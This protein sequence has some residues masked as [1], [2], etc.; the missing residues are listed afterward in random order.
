M[1][2]PPALVTR[3]PQC[4]PGLL[5]RLDPG[6]WHPAY[7]ELRARC[8]LPLAPFGDFIAQIRYG[9]IVTGKRSPPCED[10]VVVIH[11]GQVGETGVDPRGAIRV[12]PGSDW[13][14]P[15]ARLRPDDLV[16]PR[17]GV[18]SLAR[19]RAAV[20]LGD[21][22]AVVGS[23]VDLL[24]L[25][26]LDPCYALLCVK[27]ELVWSQIHRLINGVGTPNISFDEVRSL[28]IPVVSPALQAELGRA[29]RAQVHAPHLAAL[30]GDAAAGARAAAALRALVGR[31]NGLVA[32]TQMP[33]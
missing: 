19:N 10:G 28:Q 29:Y 8:A 21:Y 22:D 2:P 25:R 15:G 20:F 18:A 24:R 1:K 31:L 3:R 13:D 26:R 30:A 27:T 7:D 12:P 23:F 9:P 6:Y 14:A 11:Q 32:G 17:S 5:S 4:D 16:L 33:L